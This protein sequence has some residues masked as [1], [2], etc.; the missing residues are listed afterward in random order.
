MPFRSPPPEGQSGLHCGYLIESAVL[1]PQRVVW[2]P[3][4]EI[5][6]YGLRGD[7]STEAPGLSPQLEYQDNSAIKA[8]RL[9]KRP[10]LSWRLAI[11]ASWRDIY[12]ATPV[13]LP[14][15]PGV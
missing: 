10:Q 8:P 13:H 2:E 1:R 5:S 12:P 6:V 3:A 9:S 11:L 4:V 7:S 15:D 14:D